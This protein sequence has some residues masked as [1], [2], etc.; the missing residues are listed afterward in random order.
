MALD[1]WML[2][3]LI[4]SGVLRADGVTRRLSYGR[5]VECRRWILRALDGDICAVAVTLELGEVDRLNEFVALMQGRRTYEV[6]MLNRP[7]KFAYCIEPRSAGHIAG[8]IQR[9]AVVVEHRCP[10][11]AEAI[12][13]TRLRMIR[14]EWPDEAPF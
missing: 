12:E 2:A 9:H 8:V 11:E 7:G 6:C 5:C 1:P 4:A 13:V 10:G 14:R 3:R